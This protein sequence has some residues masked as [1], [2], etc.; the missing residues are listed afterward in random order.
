MVVEFV[1]PASGSDERFWRLPPAIHR[2]VCA[3]ALTMIAVIFVGSEHVILSRR[4]SGI[5]ATGFV[6]S[7]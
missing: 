2:S 1:R 4:R 7:T 6:L 3:P 5:M